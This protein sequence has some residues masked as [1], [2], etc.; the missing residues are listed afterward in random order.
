MGLI[1]TRLKNQAA[2]AAK[3][4]VRLEHNKLEKI[5]VKEIGS[6]PLAKFMRRQRV[7]GVQ[8]VRRL[9]FQFP[10]HHPRPPQSSKTFPQAFPWGRSMVLWV[11]KIWIRRCCVR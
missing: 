2:N 8:R 1:R 9:I 11:S 10:C 4:A 7:N 3:A 6:H 5:H